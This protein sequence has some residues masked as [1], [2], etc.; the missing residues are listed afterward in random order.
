[1]G[2]NLSTLSAMTHLHTFQHEQ[3]VLRPLAEVFGF[4]ADAA[5]L[6]RLTPPFLKFQIL[7]PLPIE[8]RAGTLIDYR[9]RLLGVPFRWKTLI[10]LFEPEQRFID[11]QLRGPYRTW[12]HTHEFT[13]V[14][15]GTRLGDR[16]DY[17]I[18]LGPLGEIARSL[19]VE[20]TV[21]EIFA[22][23]TKIIEQVFG[24]GAPGVDANR[25]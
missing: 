3:I 8:M 10:E 11:V 18:A 5:N 24:S 22:Y 20:R 16:V 6:E 4:F 14:E 7:T 15:G 25:R 19:F 1:M 9:L 13:A 2:C 17:A 21:R 23:R 12:R